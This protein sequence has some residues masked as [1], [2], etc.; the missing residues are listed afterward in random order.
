MT[1]KKLAIIST[2]FWI[3]VPPLQAISPSDWEGIIGGNQTGYIK[4]ISELTHITGVRLIAPGKNDS[5]DGTYTLSW[6]ALSF[7]L[8]WGNGAPVNIN[9]STNTTYRLY[10]S[11]GKYVFAVTNVAEL[12]TRNKS[13]S[14]TINTISA[15][16]GFGLGSQVPSIIDLKAFNGYLYAGLEGYPNGD[17]VNLYRSIDGVTWTKVFDNKL[18]GLGSAEDHADDLIEFNGYLYL[19]F[20]HTNDNDPNGTEIWRSPD[21]L[22]WE[23]V[24][25]DGFG[26]G[27]TNENG[28]PT[29]VFN[30]YLYVATINLTQGVQI[31]RTNDGITWEQTG[32]NGLGYG[33]NVIFIEELLPYGGYLYAFNFISSGNGRVWRTA[34]GTNWEMI[35]EFGRGQNMVEVIEYK[36][37]MY[38]FLSTMTHWEMH[39]SRNGS[40]WEIVSADLGI[41]F[42]IGISEVYTYNNEL[43]AISDTDSIVGHSSDAINWTQINTT[44]FGDS[45]NNGLWTILAYEGYLYV[46]FY[47]NSSGT[48]LWRA[49]LADNGPVSLAFSTKVRVNGPAN[50][51]VLSPT[52]PPVFSWGGGQAFKFQFALSGSATIYSIPSDGWSDDTQLV[53]SADD[54]TNFAHRLLELGQ[55]VYWRVLGRDENGVE[56]ASEIRQFR[57]ADRKRR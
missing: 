5:D 9:R 11:N 14:I 10:D 7:Q 12:P 54:W 16:K 32:T 22:L 17:R 34:N 55:T 57:I 56:T 15:T 33:K 20:G 2:I 45:N 43:Y 51:V 28:T 52:T 44:D 26:I 48:E 13:D 4:T 46:G 21:G 31:W 6:D 3:I 24:V 35:K 42:E 40:D 50:N 29:A 37:Y 53:I 41:P 8:T 25:F 39:K 30:G 23:Q 49:P 47:N 38:G 1:T 18:W 36:G 27:A 19:T